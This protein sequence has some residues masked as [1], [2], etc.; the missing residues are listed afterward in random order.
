MTLYTSQLYA[1][2]KCIKIF[3]E[4]KVFSSLHNDYDGVCRF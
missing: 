2:K 3:T 4:D 1:E